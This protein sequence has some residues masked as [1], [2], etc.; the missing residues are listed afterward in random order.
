M[1]QLGIGLTSLRLLVCFLSVTCVLALSACTSGAVSSTSSPQVA[2]ANA[3]EGGFK[4]N[5]WALK[6]TRINVG[7]IA[8]SDTD[9]VIVDADGVS[10]A[11]LARLKRR[12]DG[13]RRVVLGYLNI[14]E[15]ETFRSYWRPAWN[16]NR[17]DWMGKP[18]K[19][20]PGH[21]F[22]EYW[23]PE[24]QSITARGVDRIAAK[25]FDGV[26]LDSVDKYLVWPERPRQAR[27]D[28]L[29]QI[30]S[31][32][33]RGRA[34]NPQFLVV[35]NN[36]EDLLTDARY[37]ATIDAVVKE[38]LLYGVPRLGRR[39]TNEMVSWSVSRL[40]RAQRAGRPILVIEY[41]DSPAARTEVANRISELGMLVTF[42]QRDLS[43][44]TNSVEAGA[45]AVTR[46][47]RLE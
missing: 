12:P 44:L 45:N 4:L 40:K 20:W 8:R 6:L 24:W 5:R 16:R 33:R 31:I 10:A 35:P 30:E 46:L 21:Y 41:L 36:A 13:G 7:Q 26:F 34:R 18:N 29:N 14:G 43:R 15:A 23:S 1:R 42:G 17:P 32:A 11:E 22:V 37:V 2:S 3:G 27:R 9:L 25:G 39:N 19:N 28:M 38:S 47:R